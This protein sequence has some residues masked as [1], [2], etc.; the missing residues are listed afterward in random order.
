MALWPSDEGVD[1]CDPVRDMPGWQGRTMIKTPPGCWKDSDGIAPGVAGLHL[2]CESSEEGNCTKSSCGNTT[3][4]VIGEVCFKFTSSTGEESP[5]W[6]VETNPGIDVCHEHK[7]GEGHPDVFDCDAFCN[8]SK[9]TTPTK[10]TSGKCVSK[11][12][13]DRLSAFCECEEIAA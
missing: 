1:P 9:S 12:V 4:A 5:L 8:G 7:G 13:D 2:H 3:G 10:T 6:L 11:T